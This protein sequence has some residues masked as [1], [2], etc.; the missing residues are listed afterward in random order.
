MTLDK[1]MRV[2]IKVLISNGTDNE[3]ERSPVE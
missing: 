1:L 3:L 2:L